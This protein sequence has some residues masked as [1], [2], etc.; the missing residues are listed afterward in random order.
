[1]VFTSV[2]GHMMAIDFP[3]NYKQWQNHDPIVLFQAPIVKYVPEVC[4][5]RS[6]S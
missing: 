1:M 6:N 4:C 5:I 3:E 2:A